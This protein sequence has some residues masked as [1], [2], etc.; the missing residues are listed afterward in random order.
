MRSGVRAVPGSRMIKAVFDTNL[1]VSAFLSRNKPG[2]VSNELLRFARQGAIQLH[3]SPEIIAEALATLVE[4]ERAQRR[5]Q[6]TPSM[7]FQFC[8]DLL[9]AA[10]VV[11][12]PPPTPGAVPRDP[13]DDKIIAC[14]AAAGTEYL[15]SRDRDL[16]SL[17]SYGQTTIIAPEDFLRVVRRQP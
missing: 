15:V 8:D 14:A 9:A 4:D 7:V 3:L 6:Y 2:G 17:G 12:N 5:Y 10:A 13:D 1:L 11:V 16:L